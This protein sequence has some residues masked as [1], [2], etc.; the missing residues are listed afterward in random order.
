MP[1]MNYAAANQQRQGTSSTDLERAC[2]R[3]MAVHFGSRPPKHKSLCLSVTGVFLP[4]CPGVPFAGIVAEAAI[5]GR[6]SLVTEM[7]L[8]PSQPDMIGT[9]HLSTGHEAPAG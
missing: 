7:H 1:C 9:L 8:G 2:I 4:R 5:T 6:C 3:G